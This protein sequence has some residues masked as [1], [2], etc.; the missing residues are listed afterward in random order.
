MYALSCRRSM[1]RIHFGKTFKTTIG[2]SPKKNKD[3][4]EIFDLKWLF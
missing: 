3:R 1:F 4:G 2:I